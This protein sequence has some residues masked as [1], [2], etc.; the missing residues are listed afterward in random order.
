MKIEPYKKRIIRLFFLNLFALSFAF[1]VSLR[2]QL[3]FSGGIT[4]VEDP[5]LL[6]D[7]R[8]EDYKTAHSPKPRALT[9][10]NPTNK[11]KQLI[12]RLNNVIK[13][14]RQKVI[15]LVDT[16]EIVWVG[17][18]EEYLKNERFLSLSISKSV[19]SVA[20]GIAVCQGQLTLATRAK[21][22]IDQLVEKDLGQANLHQLLTMA[23]G[24]WEG[25]SDS[26]ITSNSER[27]LLATGAIG[28]LDLLMSEKISSAH[29]N[30]I[31][32]QKRRPG[33]TFSY[34][35]TDPLVVAMMLEKVTGKSYGLFL[36]QEIL[37]P[38]G[39]GSPAISGRDFKGFPRAD[40]VLRLTIDDWVRL[41]I[42]IQ[43]AKQKNNCLGNFLSEATKTQILNR[44]GSNFPARFRGYG[45]YFGTDNS[46][47]KE[48]FWAVGFGGQRIGWSMNGSKIIISFSNSD[49]KT[50]QIEE[51]FGE[52]VNSK[53]D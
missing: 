7:G 8:F 51:L 46:Y 10:R 29:K 9:L 1:P 17:L 44:V 25:N 52:W 40:G 26:S 32:S 42:W 24:T 31:F 21:D 11:E 20:T 48:T 5:V 15:V 30:S 18:R 28:H 2:A 36:E 3:N 38:A 47:A 35:S 43:E 12:E 39:I 23:S 16:G 53:Q 41:A 6:G 50:T 33:E 49:Q 27:L 37:V 4:S 34:R 13:S 19:L 22:V 14:S 45:Y